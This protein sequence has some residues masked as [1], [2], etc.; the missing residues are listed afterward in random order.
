MS[1]HHQRHGADLDLPVPNAAD[2][3]RLEV[4]VDGLGVAV[5]SGHDVGVRP[6]Q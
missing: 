6:P 2:G 1:C 3:R 4:V 5:G